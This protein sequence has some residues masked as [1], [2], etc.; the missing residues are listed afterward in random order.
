MDSI[1]SVLEE[2]AVITLIPFCIVAICFRSIFPKR[3]RTQPAKPPYPLKSRGRSLTL[4]LQPSS[5]RKQ[6][7]DAQVKSV[8]LSKLPLEIRQMIWK[9]CVGNRTIGLKIHHRR[10]VSL[11]FR[12]YGTQNEEQEEQARRHFNGQS[13][14][15]ATKDQYKPH[16]VQM[17]RTCRQM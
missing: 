7:T 11:V 2:M 3:N 1:L 15:K 13:K 10:L 14:K 4:P 9:E 6:R 17:L 12:R 16:L 8:L 5:G